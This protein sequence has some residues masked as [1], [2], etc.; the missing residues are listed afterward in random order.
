[1]SVSVVIPNLNSPLLT[2]VLAA[3]S[4][5]TPAAQLADVI[6]V[7]QHNGATSSPQAHLVN[8]A[9][10]V[11][12]AVARNLGARLAQGDYLLFLDADCVATPDLIARLLE[13][14]MQGATVVGGSVAL[15]AGDYWRLCDN[16]LAF[17]PFLATAP[18]GPRPYL[19]SLNLMLR[20]ELFLAV[21]GFAEHFPGAAGEDIDFSLRLRNAGHT[22][23]FEPRA[24]IFH[25]PPRTSARSVARHLRTYGRAHLAVQ[26]EHTG[27]AA[28]RLN[29]RMRPWSGFMLAVAPLL[30]LADALN[31]LRR[32]PALRRYWR[33]LPGLTWA[34]TAWYWGVAEGLLATYR[35][36]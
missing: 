35:R 16:L 12:A 33:C 3:L 7:G 17:T 20:R 9:Q 15:E 14:A 21:G 4:Q 26:R 13:R 32:N 18:A 24:R 5:Q 19:P 34:K 25:R 30:A 29:P 2:E 31:L 27:R 1:M 10:P 23:Y 22:L 6:V 36:T 28:P 8:T 11:A